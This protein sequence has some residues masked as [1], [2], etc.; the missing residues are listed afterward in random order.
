MKLNYKSTELFYTT[1]GTGN[2][3]V[4]LHGFLESSKI[5]EPFI[6]KLSAK[7]Q[8]ICID[9]P[10]HGKSGNISDMHTMELM[11]D[12]VHE[13]LKHLKIERASLV[14]HSMGGYVSLAYME[15]FP[16]I[17]KSLILMNSTPEEDSEEKKTNRDRSI[18]I[19]RKNKKA[20]VSMAITNLLP[21]ENYLKFKKE[22][23]ELKNNA[24]Q[25]SEEGIIAALKGMKIRTNRISLLKNFRNQKYLILGKRDPVLNTD[26][27]Q[28]V[29]DFCQCKIILTETGHLSY[30]E[31]YTEIDEILHFID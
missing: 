26:D 3:L 7:R 13:I 11:A 12:A 14:G 5:W 19:I 29:G 2:P 27:T 1:K 9:L 16:G 15:K 4:F 18:A 30:M 6:E 17:T 31:N 23:D 28:S 25:M 24:N 22:I 21:P 10:G 8:V 20:F